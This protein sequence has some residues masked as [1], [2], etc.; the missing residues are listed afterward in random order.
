MDEQ[1]PAVARDLGTPLLTVTAAAGI[2]L[3]RRPM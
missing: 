1:S 2:V 3:D